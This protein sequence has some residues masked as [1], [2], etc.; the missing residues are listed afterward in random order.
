MSQVTKVTVQP[1]TAIFLTMYFIYT[2][3]AIFLY[4]NYVN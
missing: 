1:Y 4:P 3:Q 2:A